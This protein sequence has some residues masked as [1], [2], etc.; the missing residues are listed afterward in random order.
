MKIRDLFEEVGRLY[1]S[2]NDAADIAGD[3][4]NP[5]NTQIWYW[6]EEYGRDFLMG[7]E[8]VK[9]Q[10]DFT[11]DKLK[12]THV[13][14]GTISETNP[15]RIYSMMQGESWSPSGEA[16]NMIRKLGVGHTSMS[17]GDV[18]VMGQTGIMVDRTGFV[19]ITS[20]EEV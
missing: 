18:I 5:G 2:L 10:L 20:G 14:V 7:Y 11:P 19:D 12:D 3:S 13:L 1:S 8:F 15:D 16:Y 9:K 17:V 6:K 4:F